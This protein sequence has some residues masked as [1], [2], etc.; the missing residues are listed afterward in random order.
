MEN[1]YVIYLAFWKDYSQA[2]FRTGWRMEGKLIMS[3]SLVVA[4]SKHIL[5]TRAVQS[6]LYDEPHYLCPRLGPDRR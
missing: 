2:G 3:F 4:L 5:C 6:V 1:F